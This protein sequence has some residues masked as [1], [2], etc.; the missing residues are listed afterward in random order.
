MTT[1]AAR[2]RI[3]ISVAIKGARR[4]PQVFAGIDAINREMELNMNPSLMKRIRVAVRGGETFEVDVAGK[5]YV[6]AP[7]A[8]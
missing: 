1:T 8:E 4:K 3:A 7:V 6:F 5:V 2:Q